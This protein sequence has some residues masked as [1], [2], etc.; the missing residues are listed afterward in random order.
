MVRPI[1]K[2]LLIIAI[3]F[4]VIAACIIHAD[5]YYKVGRLEHKL[6]HISNGHS[7]K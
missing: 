1:Y 2:I 7:D 5:L 4:Y 3:V 6:D